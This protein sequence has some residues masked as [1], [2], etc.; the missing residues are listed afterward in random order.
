M[1]QIIVRNNILDAIEDY[2]E[3]KHINK[4]LLVCGHSLEKYG[5]GQK[6]INNQKIACVFQE[7]TPNPK[8]EEVLKGVKAYKSAGCDSIIA[9]GGGSAMDVAKAIKAFVSMPE[10]V[11]FLEEEIKDNGIVF[12]A[13]PT[14][15]GTGSEAT[16]FSVIYKDG[17]KQ[18]VEHVS[19]LPE[20]VLMEAKFLDKL[21]VYQKK[22]T[23]LDALC[24]AIES[25]WS[26]NSNDT[27]KE[28]SV[29]AIKMIKENYRGYL[30]NLPESNKSMLEAAFIAGQ[31]INI[32]KT[33][34]AHAMC[35][36][37]TTVFNLPHGHAAALCLKAVWEYTGK[38]AKEAC[39]EKLIKTL[40][41]LEE[42]ISLND[43]RK[44]LDELQIQFEYSLSK[45]QLDMLSQSVNADRLGNHPVKLDTATLRKM[46]SDISK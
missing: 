41:E 26:I 27:S 10:G 44:L 46:Y 40:N 9:V 24:H 28:Y 37:I 25:F 18:S 4:I 17:V 2:T 35:Y 19:L 29:K 3:K 15:S 7:F 22:T 30:D 33:T 1:E 23:M 45:E 13:A 5:L 31:A 34:A 39:D 21:P 12:M 42:I 36:K 8:Y 20:L 14:T 32:T 11:N 16:R 6:L 43:Y 38:L